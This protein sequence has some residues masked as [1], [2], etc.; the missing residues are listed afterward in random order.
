MTLFNYIQSPF[1]RRIKPISL[2]FVDFE[3]KIS[4]EQFSKI[5]PYMKGRD[6][7]DDLQYFLDSVIVRCFSSK[8]VLFHKQRDIVRNQH[9][10][11]LWKLYHNQ[12]QNFPSRKFITEGDISNFTKKMIDKKTASRIVMLRHI[13]IIQEI[14]K[15]STVF[16]IWLP[17]ESFA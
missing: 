17:I 3:A 11:T 15:N 16:Y 8:Y 9:D 6:T 5:P 14:R 1:V 13:Q 4:N 10:L 2:Q 12:A 7:I